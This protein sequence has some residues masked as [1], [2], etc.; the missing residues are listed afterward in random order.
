LV[1]NLY[2]AMMTAMAALEH[3]KECNARIVRQ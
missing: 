3:A 1:I 2:L